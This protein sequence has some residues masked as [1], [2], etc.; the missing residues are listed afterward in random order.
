MVTEKDKPRI[1]LPATAI[2][3]LLCVAQ[4]LD[5]MD[6]SSMGIIAPI[7]QREFAMS[8]Q[9]L[10][11]LVSGYALGFGGF[12]LL[13]G[14]VADLFGRK[15]VF[16]LS[17]AL[18][19]LA[20][21][22]GGLATSDEALIAARIAKGVFAG[23]TAPAALSLLLSQYTDPAARNRALGV[24]SATSAVGFALGMIIGGFVGDISWRLAFFLPVPVG[25]A[26]IWA[27]LLGLAPDRPSRDAKR[28]DV[29]G[30][31]MATTAL[32]AIVFGATQ[33]ATYGWG[34]DD[35]LVPLIAGGGLLAVFIA[36]QRRAK[37]PLIPLGIFR[38]PGLSYASLMAF[39]LQGNYIGFQFV[40]VLYLQTVLHWT[41]LQS[42][43][44]FALG[45]LIVMTTAT[46]FAALALR[47]GP[48]PLIVGGF[49]VET[50]A[51]AWFL[52]AG[53][54]PVI[55]LV[56]VMGILLGSG[57]AA[58]FPAIN[59]RGLS[60]TREEEHGLASGIILSAFSIGG[61]MVL[62]VVASVFA[63]SSSEGLV[64]FHHAV[65]LVVVLS[66]ITTLMA[67]FGWHRGKSKVS[68]GVKQSKKWKTAIVVWLAIYPLITA[69]FLAFGGQIGQIN[70][71]PLRTLVLT[72]VIVP[73]MVYILIPFV[74][75]V[76]SR[77]LTK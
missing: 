18:F 74:Q 67:V 77:W 17:M 71:I 59:I 27:G 13:G 42:A 68:R 53:T 4:F 60:D 34:S 36:Y 25:L 21:L 64:R 73:F 15:R 19:V 54:I 10:Q 5:A 22:V 39:M 30:A 33:A 50:L 52:L 65:L 48:L 61:G 20:S 16:L 51:F 57:F 29:M 76:L 37:V 28:F 38:R 32:L 75:R 43:L 44:A 63:A 56:V 24:Y 47:I 72:L 1:A 62:S 8:P 70:P 46:K 55:V 58:T 11:W 26:V 49:V 6:I 45:G 7:I 2:L 40:V 66:I 12:L 14:R 31:V 9:G 69:I 41:A 3:V 23:F 35:A